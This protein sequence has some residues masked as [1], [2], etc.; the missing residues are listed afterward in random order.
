M[1]WSPHKPLEHLKRDIRKHVE[2]RLRRPIG[3][4][5][6]SQLR[7]IRCELGELRRRYRTRHRHAWAYGKNNAR[8]VA[9]ALAYY[10]Y[11]VEL[12]AEALTADPTLLARRGWDLRH[13]HS[14]LDARTVTRHALVGC[15]AAPELYGLLRYL[16]Q[17]LYLT[18][19]RDRASPNL[20]IS[21]YEPEHRKWRAIF[22]AL[23]WPLLQR[24]PWLD[25]NLQAGNVR[26]RW[27]SADARIPQLDLEHRYDFILLQLVLN[28]IEPP[29]W[30]SWLAR[31]LHQC[32]APGGLLCVIDT[33]PS[34]HDTLARQL[35]F[36]YSAHLDLRWGN[37]ESRKLDAQ[38]S[39]SLFPG[40]SHTRGQ[41]SEREKL[42]MAV[43]ASF[44]EGPV[45]EADSQHRRLP[46]RQASR[47][48][49]RNPRRA[50]DVRS[51]A[52]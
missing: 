16:S 38:T 13:A 40:P 4:L 32:L 50:A 47:V 12:A 17:N 7:Q 44:F 2:E 6:E 29:V 35:G 1:A 28:E 30:K 27:V 14:P 23:T 45:S 21:L 18:G 25:S 48:S 51:R 5:S 11:H 31:V 49:S 36:R 19:D 33:D 46:P 41:T 24:N 3:K 43:Q 20:E 15:G 9:Y 42:R 37:G 10:P 52:P 26:I 39:N 8:L 22:D 34:V